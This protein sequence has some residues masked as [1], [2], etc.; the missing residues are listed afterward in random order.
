MKTTMTKWDESMAVRC[1][2]RCQDNNAQT[3]YPARGVKSYKTVQVKASPEKAASVKM[4]AGE[5]DDFESALSN[6]LKKKRR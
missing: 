6:V 4:I 3:N 1:L 2:A 5:W